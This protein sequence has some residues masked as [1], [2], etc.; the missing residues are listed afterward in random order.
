MSAEHRQNALA[1]IEK[2]VC[3][4][5]QNTYGDP[6]D[7]FASIAVHASEVLSRKLKEPLNPLDVAMFMICVKI[8]RAGA[9]PQHRDNLIDLAGYAVCGAGILAAEDPQ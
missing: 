8:A 1:E 9:N 6:E 5:R 7:S 4:D 3:Q 2:C